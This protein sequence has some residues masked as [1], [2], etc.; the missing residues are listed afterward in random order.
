MNICC[1]VSCFPPQTFHVPET[2]LGLGHGYGELAHVKSQKAPKYVKYHDCCSTVQEL[3]MK[4]KRG[5][6]CSRAAQVPS[7]VL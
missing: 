7:D 3:K 4:N 1:C 5:T 2:Q 6:V